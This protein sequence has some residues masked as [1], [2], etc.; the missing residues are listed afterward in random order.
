MYTALWSI[1]TLLVWSLKLVVINTMVCEVGQ[2]PSVS[3]N[4]VLLIVDGRS[5][6]IDIRG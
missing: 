2:P 3:L 5:L 1:N 4:L 6:M